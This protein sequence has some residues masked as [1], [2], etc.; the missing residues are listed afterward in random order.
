M[1]ASL[2]WAVLLGLT[3]GAGL[4]LVVAAQPLGWRP[5]LAQRVEPQLRHHIP[6]SRLLAEERPDASP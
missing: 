2:L 4:L 5:T 6:A 3:L 1:S